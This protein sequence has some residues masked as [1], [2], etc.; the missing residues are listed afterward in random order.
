MRTAAFALAL[1][2]ALCAETHRHGRFEVSFTASRDYADALHD[3]EVTIEF[4]GPSG[5]ARKQALAFW[6]GG[7]T[8]RVRFS[9]E[10]AGRWRYRTAS[11]PADAGLDGQAGEFQVAAYRGSNELYRR[12]APRLSANRRYFVHADNTPWLWLACTGWN[13]ALMSTDEEWKRYIDDRAAKRFSVIQFVT[14]QW[15]AGRADERGQ[16]AFTGVE[17]IQI[18]PEFFRRMDGKFDALNDRG[19]VAAPVLLWALTSRDR[20]SPGI[21]LP[22]AEAIVL[23]RYMVARYG[24]HHAL[25]ILG[26]DGDYTGANLDRWK[27]IGRGVF[28]A[29]LDPRPA[30]LHPGGMRDPW[31]L[32]QDEPWA[33]FFMYQSGHGNNAAKWKWNA[34]EGPGAGWRLDPPR[35]VIDGEI[36]YEQHL[37]YHD[38]QM[39]GD[40]QVRRAAYYSLL[41]APPAGVTYGAHGVWFWSRKAEIPLDHPRTGVAEPWHACLDYPGARQMKVLRDIFDAFAWWRLRPDRS[42]LAVDVADPEYRSYP[43][44]ARA[45]DG[46]FAVVYLPGNPSVALNLS[47]FRRGVTGTW[48]DPRTGARRPAGRWKPEG[49]V[50]VSAPGPGDWILVLR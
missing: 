46:S 35:P 38:R 8:W 3:V 50:E 36:N 5:S 23:A 10:L 29:H 16:V 2:A 37:D 18:N 30:T 26:G 25:W 12:G 42:L 28:P 48:F 39:I 7:R 31:P 11:R 43:M 15:R 13:S 22:T 6:D 41:S 32:F 1:S 9:P 49:R 19:L 40:A 44:P 17:R 45:E 4:T 34:T 21:A 14:T 20:E 24:A 47:G 27:A 33:S